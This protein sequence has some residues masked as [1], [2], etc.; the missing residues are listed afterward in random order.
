[1]NF[2]EKYL[3]YK[4]KYLNLKNQFGGDKKCSTCD[5][6]LEDDAT[7]CKH[8][9]TKQPPLTYIQILNEKV[10]PKVIPNEYEYNIP[11]EFKK[12]DNND[13]KIDKTIKLGIGADTY[14]SIFSDGFAIGRIMEYLRTRCECGTDY[15]SGCECP[16]DEYWLICNAEKKLSNFILAYAIYTNELC[17][18]SRP[19]ILIIDFIAPYERINLQK[20]FTDDLPNDIRDAFK[21]DI[22]KEASSICDMSSHD[23]SLQTLDIDHPHFNRELYGI[24]IPEELF[25]ISNEKYYK[26]QDESDS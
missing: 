25:K 5:K 14:V 20:Y 15:E 9:H 3:K 12:V 22:I 24:N 17:D 13:V 6:I 19:P 2:Q 10:K 11:F 16:P 4:K 21:H 1:M 8:C 7:V 26:D 23:K 18:Y